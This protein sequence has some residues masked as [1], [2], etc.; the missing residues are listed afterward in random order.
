MKKTISSLAGM[1]GYSPATWTQHQSVSLPQMSAASVLRGATLSSG[2]GRVTVNTHS[3]LAK[4][5]EEVGHLD[6]VSSS[7][8]SGKHGR[9]PGAEGLGKTLL[10]RTGSL[11]L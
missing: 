5:R 1:K 9:E 7:Q 10:H 2:L 6:H 11:Q 8:G 3:Q 4:Y